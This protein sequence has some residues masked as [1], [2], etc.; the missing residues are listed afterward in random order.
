MCLTL[1]FRLFEDIKAILETQT[2]KTYS[3]LTSTS[4]ITDDIAALFVPAVIYIVAGISDKKSNNR[5][6]KIILL[7]TI[8][9]FIAVMVLTGD[10]RYQ[11]TAII[12]IT[13]CYIYSTE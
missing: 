2:F 8:F 4:G 10:R 3:A 9:Y 5:I 12:S 7:S 13:L 11:T 6:S 1:P